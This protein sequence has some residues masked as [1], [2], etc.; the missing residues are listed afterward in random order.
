[1]KRSII[2]LILSALILTSCFKEDEKVP[3]HDPGNLIEDEVAMGGTYSYQVYY[4]LSSTT[5]I[6]SNEK[7]IY[8]L[9]FEPG[10]EGWHVLLNTA[11]FMYAAGTGTTDFSAP[12]DTTGYNWKFDKSDGNLDSTAIGNYF[13]YD[14]TDS[15]RIYSNEVYVLNRGYDINANLRGLKKV[16]IQEV[17]DSTY[18]IRYANIDGSDEN[19]FTIEKEDPEMA[20]LSYFSFSDGGTQIYPEP[21]PADYDLLFTQYTTLLYT[22]IGDPYP[23]LLTGVLVNR[24][25]VRTVRDTTISFDEITYETA[26]TMDFTRQLDNIGYDW[27][28]LEGDVTGGGTPVYLIVEDLHYIIRDTEGFLYKFRFVSFYNSDGVKGYP[29]IEYQRL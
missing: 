17:S 5:S 8:D 23:Y 24:Q 11:T 21:L 19:T 9:V 13:S 18:T 22:D 29:N 15:T 12:I 25:R 6:S 28:V 26:S 1:M 2:Y 3:A 7:D 20:S 14:L 10:E 16:V 4:D 27:K